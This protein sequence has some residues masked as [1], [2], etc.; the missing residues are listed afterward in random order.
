[1]TS[2]QDKAGGKPT[3]PEKESDAVRVD[4]DTEAGEVAEEATE[5]L[6]GDGTTESAVAPSD[7]SGN[8][9]DAEDDVPA[10]AKRSID[11]SRLL[12]YGVLPALAL[13]L[14]A[15]AGYFRWQDSSIRS[16]Q[17][18]SVESVAAARDGTI[19][20]LSYQPDTVDK[21]LGAARAR[22]TGTF[23]ESYTQLTNDVVIPGAKQRHISAVATVPAAASVS[24]TVG[25]AVALVFVNQTVVVGAD[26][27]SATASSV[28]VTL[29]K[30]GDR[31]LISGFDPV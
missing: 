26:A 27:P 12:A 13:L 4:T 18:G 21:D 1:M 25:H 11:F 6:E 24:A 28:R 19:A 8:D 9:H 20:M 2:Q 14:A 31:W 23:K 10:K 29:D 16:S 3:E 5:E 7:D 17:V 15:A 30:V 22:L